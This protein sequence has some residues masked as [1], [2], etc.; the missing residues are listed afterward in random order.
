MLNKEFALAPLING[1]DMARQLISSA[2]RHISF[3]PVLLI[4]ILHAYISIILPGQ[5]FS[6]LSPSSDAMRRRTGNALR[7]IT[8]AR[9]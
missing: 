7:L 1:A 9:K 4:A 3:M 8:R 5:R 2:F 6:S